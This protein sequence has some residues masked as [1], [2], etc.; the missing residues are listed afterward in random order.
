MMKYSGIVEQKLNNVNDFDYYP[1]IKLL[2]WEY[3]KRTLN[4]M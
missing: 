1:V 3:P 2:T 4:G